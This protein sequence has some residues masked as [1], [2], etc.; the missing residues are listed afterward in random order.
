MEMKDAPLMVW[1]QGGPGGSSLV[2]MLAENGPCLIKA[3]FNDTQY[4]PYSWTESYN[5]LYLD[6]PVGVGFSY[7]DEPTN[8]SRYPTRT[9]ESAL[10]FVAVIKLVHEAFV[11]L[12]RVPLHI[13]GESYAGRYVPEFGAAVLEYNEHVSKEAQIPLVSIMV[14][15]GLT[16][17]REQYPSMYDTGC[18]ASHG[19]DPIFNETECEV[20]SLG[21]DRCEMLMEK[22]D[23]GSDPILCNAAGEYC[24][25]VVWNIIE[26]KFVNRYDRTVMC[27]EIGNC[28]PT[29]NKMSHWLNSDEVQQA[30]EIKTETQGKLGAYEMENK[31]IEK[32]FFDSGDFH[33]SSI[34]ALQRVLNNPNVDVLYYSGVND[35]VCNSLGISRLLDNI[36]WKWHAKFRALDITALPWKTAAGGPGGQ[37]RNVDGLWHV[38]LN[39]GGH[40]VR[41]HTLYHRAPRND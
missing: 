2:G 7:I 6:Q 38:E 21:I 3:D 40:L 41:I 33:T 29:I 34:P 24:R 8:L 19:I 31:I 13:A 11:E 37:M 18:F 22:C 10:D 26:T 32:N 27:P 14:G 39:G 17:A 16:S 23:D 12:S 30:F 28:Y 9:E 36:R 35:W 1:L 5:V 4:N 20:M 15:N 25:T